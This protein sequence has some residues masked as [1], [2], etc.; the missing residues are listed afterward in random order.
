MSTDLM[1]I[2]DTNAKDLRWT[3]GLLL[4]NVDRWICLRYLPTL[5]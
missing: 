3:L 4:L 1:S 5:G 2:V